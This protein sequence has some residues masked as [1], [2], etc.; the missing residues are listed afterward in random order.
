MKPNE[1][2]AEYS[3]TSV[4]TTECVNSQTHSQSPDAVCTD[5]GMRA[6]RRETI[7]SEYRLEVVNCNSQVTNYRKH[8]WEFGHRSLQFPISPFSQ[9]SCSHLPF[10]LHLLRLLSSFLFTSLPTQITTLSCCSSKDRELK[11]HFE[12]TNKVHHL[13][14]HLLLPPAST[15]RAK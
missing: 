11:A 13:C 12:C 2:P 15:A 1:L 14:S 7:T 5:I 6:Y 3:S 4:T 9:P 10:L 8:Q